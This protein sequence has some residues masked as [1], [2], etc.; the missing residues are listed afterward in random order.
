MNLTKACLFGLAIVGLVGGQQTSTRDKQRDE[1]SK[2]FVFEIRPPV[3]A[4]GETA[5][6]YWSIKGATKVTIEQVPASKRDLEK[7]GT[8]AGSGQL[9][10]RPREDTTYVVSCEGSTTLVC[11]SISVRVR[12]KQH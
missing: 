10:V 2:D 11:A 12:V 8:F 3:I 4:P 9:E 6:L 5:V 1:R 7:I